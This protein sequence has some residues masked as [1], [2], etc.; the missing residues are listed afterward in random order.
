[1]TKL[2]TF[3]REWKRENVDLLAQKE[4]ERERVFATSKASENFL[5]I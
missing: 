2:G 4:L 1:M 3:W 5:F